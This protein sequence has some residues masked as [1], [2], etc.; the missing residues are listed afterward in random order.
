MKFNRRNSDFEWLETNGTGGYASSTA[1]FVNK[2]KYHGLL[3]SPLDPP[4]NRNV[5]IS[6]IDERVNGNRL[7]FI[8]YDFDLFHEFSLRSSGIYVKKK[9]FMPYRKSATIIEYRMD[10]FFE[11]D[12][13]FELVPMFVFRHMYSVSDRRGEMSMELCGKDTGLCV[14]R[15]GDKAFIT[16]SVPFLFDEDRKTVKAYYPLDDE[17]KEDCYEDLFSPGSLF[18]D[19]KTPS[20]LSIALSMNEPYFDF[21]ID[22]ERKRR[23]G[24]QSAFYSFHPYKENDI[25]NELILSADRFIVDRNGRKSVIAGYHWFADWG[26]DALISL[27]GLLLVTRR[28]QDAKDVLLTF[29][30][31]E[32]D[33][34]IPNGFTEENGVMY[35][36][37]D[38]SLWFIDRV[39]RY[40]LYTNDVEFLKG[41]WDKMDSIVYSYMKGTN[42][43]KMD[44]DFLLMH[45]DQLT[46]MDAMVEGRPCTPRGPK[47]VEV[48]GL[49][50]NAL[51]VLERMAGFLEYDTEFYRKICYGIEASFE[52]KFFNGNYFA[53]RIGENF[54]DNALR[55]NQ[56]IALSLEYVPVH[57]ENA[58]R[59]FEA[60]RDNLLTPFGLRTL[61]RDDP[62]YVGRYKGSIVERDRAYHS[63][64][65]W[66]WLMGPFVT[67]YLK[68]SNYEKEAR[69]FAYENLIMPLM[70]EALPCGNIEE[71][72]SGDEPFERGGCISQAWSVA[73]VLR[74]MCEDIMLERPAYVSSFLD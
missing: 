10:S 74:C 9:L 42:G 56:V 14:S 53:D 21:N 61:S 22:E 59:A 8:G 49:W 38:T 58:L 57:R 29:L 11:R 66:P 43:I 13:R 15:N 69:E 3:I 73:E 5:I 16:S 67:T 4:V 28:F 27:P 39:Y 46:W 23:E 36:S 17:R 37:V 25:L 70:L 68:L 48:Q 2:R 60:V 50:Y 6:S 63:G 71:V 19:M 47:A 44:N 72:C 62:A 45:G 30:N 34:L 52:R 26:R 1:S 24:L 32:R 31:N 65:V 55:P 12:F 20:T 51:K 33:G 54:V 18:I 40:F 41:V 35:N 64:T 7:D